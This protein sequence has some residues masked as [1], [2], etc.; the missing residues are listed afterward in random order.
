MVFLLGS[1]EKAV[2]QESTSCCHSKL[3][4]PRCLSAQFWSSWVSK[5]NCSSLTTDHKI[6]IIPVFYSPYGSLTSH[7]S[8][9]LLQSILRPLLRASSTLLR[10]PPLLLSCCTCGFYVLLVCNDFTTKETSQREG[11]H[12]IY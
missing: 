8:S 5:I 10:V 4:F 12:C 9:Y 6:C 3:T 1:L 7:C 2:I 11:G